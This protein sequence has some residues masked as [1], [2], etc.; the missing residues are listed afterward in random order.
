MSK[1]QQEFNHKLSQ[2]VAKLG[3]MNDLQGIIQ[4]WGTS[5]ATEAEVLG[6]LDEV[7]ESLPR[8]WRRGN[9]VFEQGV[10]V[11]QDDPNGLFT[12]SVFDK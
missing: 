1:N 4:M 3:G 9:F 12:I 10:P 8:A 11:W 2:I 7:L 6:M 5:Q